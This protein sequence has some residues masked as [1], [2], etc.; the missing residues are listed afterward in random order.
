[1]NLHIHLLIF[2]NSNGNQ[3][4]YVV[5]SSH[6]IQV[7]KFIYIKTG[8]YKVIQYYVLAYCCLTDM[9]CPL[10]SLYNLERSSAFLKY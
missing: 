3:H 6:Q 5:T 4:S 1:M 10:F 2:S 7:F 9:F 8:T